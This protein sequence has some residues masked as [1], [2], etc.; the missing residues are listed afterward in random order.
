MP[1]LCILLIASLMVIFV[2]LNHAAVP[3]LFATSGD[4]LPSLAP[5]LVKVQPAIVNISTISTV[6]V[7]NSLFDEPGLRRFFGIPNQP[8]SRPRQRQ[9]TETS[10]GSGVI[11]DASNG[12]V[13]TNHHV[14]DK[15]DKITVTTHG[16]SELDAELIGSDA[17][18][19][20]ALIKVDSDNLTEIKLGASQELRVGDFVVA[21][22]SPFGLSQ[23]VTSGIISALGRSG[24]GIEE[25]EDFIQTDA[26]INPGNSGGALVNL[27]GE[28]IGINTAILS[29]GGGSV[30]IG[31]SIPVD[32]V[33]SLMPQLIQ[34]GVVER[35]V[36]GVRIQDLT[37]ALA[38]NLGVSDKKGALIVGIEPGSEAEDKGIDV[39]DIIIKFNNA[40][41]ESGS[42]LRNAVGLVRAGSSATIEY[43]RDGS[44]QRVA[45]KIREREAKSF[46]FDDSSISRRLN[47]ARFRT[48]ESSEDFGLDFKG[49]VQIVEIDPN[50]PAAS[51]GLRKDDVI[52]AINRDGVASIKQMQEV[53]EDADSVLVIK[54]IRN[55]RLLLLAIQ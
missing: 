18:S 25:Y 46:E 55:E 10:L 30:G 6:P 48:V 38:K 13:I 28:L 7:S 54:L 11:V 21:I 23:S 49:G 5:M 51:S 43:Y 3:L 39:G 36:L 24:L 17:K 16:G 2:P 33:K 27:R 19:D 34:Y 8:N 29:R 15:A 40:R 12:Y 53:L 42:D 4:E 52:V 26:S 50:S 35:G 20:I 41:I 31:L 45:V 1:R 47:G 37:P 14:I 9:R 22:G 32:M 44:L